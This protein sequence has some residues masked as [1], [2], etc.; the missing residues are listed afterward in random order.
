MIK[1]LLCKI[2]FCGLKSQASKFEY[3]WVEEEQ[4]LSL[5]Q[6][7]TDFISV[8]RPL[9]HLSVAIPKNCIKEIRIFAE[10]ECINT[11]TRAESSVAE[12]C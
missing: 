9:S 12:I 5:D 6:G 7:D 11:R 2:S 3:G 8:E 10:I 4:I 1:K